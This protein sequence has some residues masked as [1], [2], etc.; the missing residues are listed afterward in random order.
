MWSRAGKIVAAGV[1]FGG[2]GARFAV[3]R[4]LPDGAPDLSFGKGGAARATFEPGL[5]SDY[6]NALALQ[7]DGKIVVAGT[8]RFSFSAP[9]PA[10][11]ALA[12]Y[13]PNGRLDRSFAGDG[14]QITG[15]RPHPPRHHRDYG[16][17]VA[18]QANGRIVA[19]G[20][21][22]GNFALARYLGAPTN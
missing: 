11:F 3:A 14:K 2:R 22:G 5:P 16:M 10:R 19:V 13:T 1:D 15:F 21:A 9:N 4:Y 7:E 12:R 8:A 17:D 6:A 20:Q 18:I